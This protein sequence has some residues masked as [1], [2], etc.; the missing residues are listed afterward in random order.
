[1]KLVLQRKPSGKTAT[2]G[3]LFIDGRFECDTLEDVVRAEKIHGRTA[4]PSGTYKVKLTHSPRFKRI[5]PLIENVPGFEGVRIHPGNTSDDTEGCILPGVWEEG[6]TIGFS[7]VT[8]NK[9]YNRLQQA[10][11]ITIE[12]RNHESN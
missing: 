10:D 5:L 2:I 1:M 7:R 12:V 9:L 6:E 11:D 8:F 3:E 4:I